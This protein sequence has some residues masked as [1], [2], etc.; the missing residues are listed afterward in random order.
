MHD[1]LKN[2]LPLLPDEETPRDYHQ[3]SGFGFFAST[4]ESRRGY[5][6]DEVSFSTDD[7]TLDYME[8]TVSFR[9]I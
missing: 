1:L 7:R 4:D 9:P 5:Y 8:V 2:N 3:L 6:I